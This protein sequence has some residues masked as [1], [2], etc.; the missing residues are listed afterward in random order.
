MANGNATSVGAISLDLGVSTSGLSQAINE[1][2]RNASTQLSDAFRT[3]LT[4]CENSIN[5]IGNSLSQMTSGMQSNMNQM[6]RSMTSAFQNTS[7]DFYIKRGTAANWSSRE[8][9]Q[10]DNVIN[11][12]PT[13]ATSYQ[14]KIDVTD[15]KGA[16][17]SKVLS[18]SAVS[19]SSTSS[20]SSLPNTL[21]PAADLT[22][23]KTDLEEI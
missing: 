14:V 13:S 21:S 23:E 1:A 2:A 8:P 16:I 11:L 18:F 20:V 17:A 3:A 15:S 6:S 22:V 7:Y 12:R 9:D 4:G 10:G 5:G 19:A